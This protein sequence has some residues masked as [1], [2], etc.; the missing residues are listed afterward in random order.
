MLGLALVAMTYDR[1]HNLRQGCLL[2]GDPD[3][4][5]AWEL[6]AHDG[7]RKPFTPDGRT[8]LAFAQAAASAF[9]VGESHTVDFDS[10]AA[11]AAIKE[12]AGAKGKA[13][14]GG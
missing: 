4:P 3:K 2:V 8:A 11:N 12:K 7:V 1:E 6:V 10:K 5:A 14:K 13:K 9:G